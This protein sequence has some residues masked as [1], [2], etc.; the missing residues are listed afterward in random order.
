MS[1]VVHLSDDAHARAKRHCQRS[2]L[3]MSEWV[4]VLIERATAEATAG[5]MG[6]KATAAA[7]PAQGKGLPPRRAAV[8]PPQPAEAASAAGDGALPLYAAPPFW[9]RGTVGKGPLTDALG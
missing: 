4:A 9:A 6:G 3:K 1:K 8:A 5:E 2:G 7:A